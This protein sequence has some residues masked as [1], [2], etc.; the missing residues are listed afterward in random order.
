MGIGTLGWAVTGQLVDVTNQLP[1]YRANIRKK[2]EALRSPKN[3][4]LHQAKNAVT[5]IGNELTAPATGTT[6]S[7]PDGSKSPADKLSPSPGTPAKPIPVEVVHTI[8]NPLESLNGLISPIGTVAIVMVFTIFM[9]IRWEDLRNRFIRLAGHRHL[10]VMTQALDEAGHR[11]SRYLFLQIVVNVLYGLVIAIVLHFIGLS[12]ALLWGVTAALLRFLPYVG[13]LLGAALPTL[14]ALAIFDDWKRAVIVLVT[15]TIVELIVGNAIEP[16]LYGQHVGLSSL[17]VLVAAVFWSVLWG[18]VGLVLSTPLTVCLVVMGR[19]VPH[20]EFLDVLL[21]D[22]PVLLPQTHYYQRLLASDQ[23]E[24]KEVLDQYLKEH[25]LEE[26]YDQVLVPALRL[27]E[28][29]RHTNALDERTERFIDRTTRDIIEELFDAADGA[30]LPAGTPNSP[31]FTTVRNASF[32]ASTIVIVPATDDSDDTV[33]TMLSQLLERQGHSSRCIPLADTEES[34]ARIRET[35][36]KVVCISALPPLAIPHLRNL[37][38]Q[39]VHRWP[40]ANILVGLWGFSGDLSHAAR[41]IK[42]TEG[43]A[44]VL[45]LAQ[46]VQQIRL[47]LEGKDKPRVADDTVIEMPNPSR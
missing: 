36:P 18:P 37:Y 33:A 23:P 14:L 12:N 34:L 4:K 21:G 39:M 16:V 1:N 42:I 13:P 27:A 46:A 31:P 38:A 24:A 25:S 7:A 47:S 32:S 17:A 30:P 41:R 35:Q 6:K 15:Y 44:V 26:L 5:E 8:T 29:D 43:H 22:D 20:L 11:V 9:L 3:N 10:N 45:T 2:V 40:L 19:Y 28:E